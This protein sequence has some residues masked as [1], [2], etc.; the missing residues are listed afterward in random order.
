MARIDDAYDHD[1][2][3]DDGSTGGDFALLPDGLYPGMIDRSDF[4]ETKKKN[5]TLVKATFKVGDGEYTGRLVFCNFNIK[6]PNSQAAQIGRKQFTNLCVACGIEEG[7]PEDT[8]ELHGIPIYA[9]VRTRPAK[10][11][12]DASN[13]VKAFLSYDEGQALN[14][15]PPTK[16]A[17]TEGQASPPSSG[18]KPAKGADGS[19]P[20]GK[21]K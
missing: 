8:A 10:G 3:K 20:W 7:W 6:N 18:G 13:D 9:R 14:E 12:Y 1:N 2:D 4:V 21:K 17:A 15:P 11:G 16:S 19:F 5:G